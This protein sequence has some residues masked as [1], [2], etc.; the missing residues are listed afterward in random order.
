MGSKALRTDAKIVPERKEEAL[1]ILDS[2]II[3]LF[4]SVLD[5]KQIIERHI[6]KER[7]ANL[8]ELSHHD[9]ELKE[10]L[11]ALVNEL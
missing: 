6:L 10:T 1:K 8:I 3:K 9:E 2:L 11:H 7:L 4:V 5:E